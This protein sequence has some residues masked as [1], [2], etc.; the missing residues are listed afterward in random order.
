MSQASS[1]TPTARDI[2][3][4]AEAKVVSLPQNIMSL[5]VCVGLQHDPDEGDYAK[6]PWRKRETETITDALRFLGDEFERK[7]GAV[8]GKLSEELEEACKGLA[9][10][11]KRLMAELPKDATSA[12][13][14]DIVPIARQVHGEIAPAVGAF[15]G[16]LF[17]QVVAHEKTSAKLAQDVDANALVQIDTIARQISLIAVNAAVE[18]ARVGDAGSGFAVIASE[19]KALS[20][21]SRHAVERMR[22]AIG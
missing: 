20:E 14:S 4:I 18:A 1:R 19:I 22:T 2:A 7:F 8:V 21:K 12:S 17:T 13:E 9:T 15:L 3:N 10:A 11:L 6:D 16:A 5:L